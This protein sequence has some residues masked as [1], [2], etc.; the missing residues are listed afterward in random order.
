M[1]KIDPLN[2]QNSTHIETV[3]S[4]NSR[5]NSFNN[6]AKERLA[7]T[8]TISYLSVWDENNV[9]IESS[10]SSCSSRDI[11]SFNE[12]EQNRRRKVHR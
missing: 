3:N 6:N 12:K 9:S 2:T 7:D 5:S 1:N 10:I 4:S 8:S 11:D